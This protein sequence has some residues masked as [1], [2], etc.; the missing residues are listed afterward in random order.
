MYVAGAA[1]RSDLERTAEAKEKTGVYTGV[2]AV[3]PVNG[4]RIQIW[5]A[6]YVLIGYGTGAIMA[7]PAHDER[8]LQFAETFGL[9]IREVVQPPADLGAPARGFTGDGTA[10]NSCEFNGLSSSEF[11]EAITRWLEDRGLG[12]RAAASHPQH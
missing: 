12:G 5:V 2:D 7:V 6:D 3:N 9:P 4:D 8:D 11:R 10:I 1:N